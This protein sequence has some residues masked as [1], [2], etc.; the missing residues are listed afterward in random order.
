MSL[1]FS[2]TLPAGLIHKIDESHPS[3]F[4]TKG[5]SSM[6]LEY[7]VTKACP[8]GRD[9]LVG[10]TTAEVVEK[11]IKPYT[12][13]YHSS[14]CDL[15]SQCRQSGIG[16]ARVLISH[17][18]GG[19]F[20]DLV[21][22]LSYHFAPSPH[23]VMWLDIFSVNQH[24]EQ[25]E[26]ERQFTW[27][28]TTL[29]NEIKRFGRTVLVLSPGTVPPPAPVPVPQSPSSL[30][31]PVTPLMRSPVPP[32]PA[33][34]NSTASITSAATTTA[35]PWQDSLPLTR[36]WCLWE[37]YCTVVNKAKLEFAVYTSDD[38]EKL[39]DRMVEDLYQDTDTALE[40]LRDRIDIARAY[41]SLPFEKDNIINAILAQSNF[42]QFNK[43]VY[44][45]LVKDWMIS[46]ILARYERESKKH[47][48]D[49]EK[50]LS[51]QLILGHLYRL[52]G[53]HEKAQEMYQACVRTI[54]ESVEGEKVKLLLQGKHWLGTLLASRGK[55]REAIYIL[56]A[57]YKERVKVYGE[58]DRETLST[59]HRLS[60]AYDLHGE[61]EKAKDMYIT[62]LRVRSEVLGRTHVDTIRS[63]STLAGCLRER[64]MLSDALGL[65][66]AQYSASIE[67]FGESHRDTLLALWHRGDTL[68][69]M[70]DLPGAR[71]L[72]YMCYNRRKT[73]LGE[74]HVHTLTSMHGMAGLLVREGE[75]ECA[76][77]R[78]R[79]M[80]RERDAYGLFQ[81]CYQ[82]RKLVLGEQ[83]VD[84]LSTLQS[85]T[86]LSL[87]LSLYDSLSSM[88]YDEACQWAQVNYDLNRLK[89]GETHA[90]T[91]EALA[92]VALS[93]LMHGEYTEARTLY[94]VCYEK[95]KRVYGGTHERTRAILWQC[96][97][98]A[99]D[100]GDYP[101][102]LGLVA[103]C[104]TAR[105]K[106][107]GER[108]I[109]TL[110]ALYRLAALHGVTGDR[111]EAQELHGKC[112]EMRL[113]LLGEFHPDTMLSRQAV[114]TPIFDDV[115]NVKLVEGLRTPGARD[116]RRVRESREREIERL[117][118]APPL[119]LPPPPPPLPIEYTDGV[120]FD[121]L[122]QTA[123]E[124]VYQSPDRAIILWERCL[125]LLDADNTP[126]GLNTLDPLLRVHVC[127]NLG[128]AYR[129][130]GELE[131]AV[132]LHESCITQYLNIL[133]DRHSLTLMSANNLSVCYD[134]LGRYEDAKRVQELCLV[135]RESVLG[136]S[137]SETL[138]S[139]HNLAI[140]YG[141]CGERGRACELMAKCCDVRGR[142]LGVNHPHT[143]QSKMMLQE[144]AGTVRR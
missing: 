133:G 140:V 19:K 54:G 7:F 9:T 87:A 112:Y 123:S 85:L 131:R 81:L 38:G 93:H 43:R 30:T 55:Y 110:S 57:C 141:H 101:S 137:H 11:Y 2:V 124:C 78:E 132:Y 64:G 66:E 113:A 35:V 117:A 122:F 106:T 70:G 83:H 37:I 129:Q 58:R 69:A 25:R 61:R 128:N 34:A 4:P 12:E 41:T 31:P 33:A 13:R 72:W 44:L 90:R 29:Q 36:A 42:S 23:T 18:W 94:T 51:T 139:L 49:N 126:I 136:D 99:I 24:C 40:R 89:Y 125:S 21:D 120:P 102:A 115:A 142:V 111:A 62:C 39:K 121:I 48:V 76:V 138:E 134:S 63:M 143:I 46:V 59:L 97:Q 127:N 103:S 73:V 91:V 118:A 86:T 1:D 16:D 3:Y 77:E 68:L 22:A 67:A 47:G 88:V 27:W 28:S 17:A 60:H 65:Y 100:S 71:V 14:L 84:T 98:V 50:T 53:G 56:D 15:L 52:S 5:V 92:D 107:K 109:D 104:Y 119:S 95:A 130:I 45:S 135:G 82:K 32:A 116:R 105:R 20:L 144:L 10:M 8:G 114:F 80:V 74:N 6:F 108:D 75:R 96:A 79:D 26:G